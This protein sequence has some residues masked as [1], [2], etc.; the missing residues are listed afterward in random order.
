MNPQTFEFMND[1]PIELERHFYVVETDGD[2]ALVTEERM[3]TS[4]GQP[5]QQG[6]NHYSVDRVTMVWSRR[7]PR[8]VGRERGLLAA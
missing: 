5:L 2:L 7:L 4:G 3:M 6:V 1:L 8:G